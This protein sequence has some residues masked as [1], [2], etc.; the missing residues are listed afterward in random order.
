MHL[1][2][3]GTLEITPGATATFAAVNVDPSTLVDRHRRG[4]WG[5]MEEEARRDNEFALRNPQSFFGLL[6]KYTLTDGAEVLVITA[7]DRSATRVL[8]PAE[9]EVREVSALE[10]Y[11]VWAARYDHEPNPLIAAEE[12][13]VDTLLE[14]LPIASVLDVA[15][16]TG[17]YAL[18]LARRGAIVTAI[19]QSTEMLAVAR[20]AARAAGLAI[21]FHEGSLGEGLPFATEQF[22]LVVCALALC[23]VPDLVGAV[24]EFGRVLRPGG[25][26]L[27]T[28]FHPDVVAEGWRTTIERPGIA[29][30]LE[31]FSHTRAGY[32]AAVEGVGCRLLQ[33]IDIPL[34]DVPAGYFPP[35]MVHDLGD[36]PFGLVLLARKPISA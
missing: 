19:D 22:D 32:V 34:R 2:E 3:I 14:A 1:F 9:E 17:R 28:D 15:T 30:L 4:D 33:A 10:G 23:H 6:S 31:N 25:H 8:L 36:K 20:E 18:K 29:Y 26:L 35:W 16:G 21:D 5:D 27:I 24:A 7:A 12:P 13:V 11:A